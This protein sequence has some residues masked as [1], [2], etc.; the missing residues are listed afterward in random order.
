MENPDGDTG[1]LQDQDPYS[2]ILQDA[3]DDMQDDQ[4]AQ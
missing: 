1:A 3:N 4:D 2:S